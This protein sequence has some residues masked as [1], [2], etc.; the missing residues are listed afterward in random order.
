MT[1]TSPCSTKVGEYACNDYLVTAA[2]WESPI[3]GVTYEIGIRRKSD[4]VFWLLQSEKYNHQTVQ[5]MAEVVCITLDHFS[6]GEDAPEW[7]QE[8]LT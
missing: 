8:M 3:T 5:E 4:G 2:K 6:D 7:C 1:I